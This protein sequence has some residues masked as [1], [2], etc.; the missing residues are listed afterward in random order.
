M[1]A[2]F[3]LLSASSLNLGWSQN[4]VQANG[5]NN[6]LNILDTL[7]QLFTKPHQLLTTLKQKSFEN[8]MGKGENAG[9]QHFL[10]LPSPAQMAQW[11]ACP[12]HDLVVV[13]SI[14]S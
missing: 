11:C 10:L 3:Q 12:T 13:S 14:P 5:L 1:I 8:I 4:A 2:T 9:N 7:N 6:Y